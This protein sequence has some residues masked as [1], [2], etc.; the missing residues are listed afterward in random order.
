MAKR[1]YPTIKVTGVTADPSGLSGLQ[2]M[3]VDAVV[4]SDQIKDA[5][6]QADFVTSVLPFTEKTHKFYTKDTFDAFKKGSTFINIGRGKTVDE[7]ALIEALKDGRLM[8][9]ALDVTYIEPLPQESELWT[10]PNVM[11]Y[12]HSAVANVNYKQETSDLFYT[13]LERYLKG[14]PFDYVCDKRRGF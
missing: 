1:F 7:D 10:L 5:L 8:S 12:P 13:K 4:H 14:E 3:S 11:L 2:K 9:A 6:S